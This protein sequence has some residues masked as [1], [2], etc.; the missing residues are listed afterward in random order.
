MVAF[1][2]QKLGLIGMHDQQCIRF[3][4]DWLPRLGLRW[5]GYRKG[6]RTVCKRI[7]RRIRALDL[8]DA[9]AYGTYL[10]THPEELATLRAFC[11][12][13]ISRFYRDHA[14]YR[15]LESAAF[16]ACAVAA[17]ARGD[18]AIRCWSAGCASGEE[19]YTIRLVWD[20]AVARRFPGMTLEIVA[21]DAD[22]GLLERA[23]AARYGAG[24]L[25]ELPDAYRGAAFE[26]V[27]D[28]YRLK[29]EFRAGVRFERQDI[30]AAQPDG[31]FDLVFCRNLA[32]TYFDAG[33][34]RTVLRAILDRLRPGGFLVV[35][36][37][38]RLPD[39]AEGLEPLS[40]GVP[41][42]RYRDGPQR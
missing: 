12:I 27:D 19:P 31:P 2:S 39:A 13:S 24:S 36:A 17:R 26:R 14:V 30:C 16:P 23:A 3:L 28:G 11:C 15:L 6:R 32:F 9:E 38:E 20:I 41:I 21:T 35:G 25:K 40:A 7:A 42:Y 1:S 22:P 29:L 8:P 4:Q 5:A 37:H 18:T 10:E 33:G 34:Q